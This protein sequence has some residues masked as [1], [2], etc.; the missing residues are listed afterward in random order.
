MRWLALAGY[1]A[2][3]LDEVMRAW[4]HGGTLPTRP[5]VITFDNGYPRR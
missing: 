1:Q 3:T 4:Y 5:I 2:V